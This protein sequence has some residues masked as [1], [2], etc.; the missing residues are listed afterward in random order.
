[1]SRTNLFNN[2]DKKLTRVVNIRKEKCDVYCGRPSIYGNPFV[3]G[4]DG[5]REQVI[6]K[7][8]EYFKHRI[9]DDVIFCQAIGGLKGK[10]IGCF[11]KPLPCHLDVIA[12]FLNTGKI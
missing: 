5:T 9:H 10:K 2:E 4:K 12:E 1:M 7:Y 6:E 11:C 8:R 3:I